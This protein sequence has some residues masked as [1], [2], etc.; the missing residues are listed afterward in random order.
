MEQCDVNKTSVEALED[1]YSTVSWS[2]I[3]IFVPLITAFGLLCNSAFIFVVYRVKAMHTIT[4]VF[5][6]NLAI[7]DFS[8]LTVGLSQYIGSYANSPKYD[9]GFSFYT[10]FGCITPNFLIY[11]C[12][13]ASLWTVTLVSVERY[14]A[15]CHTIWHRHVKSTR[16]AL[17]LV[18]V[19]W[20]IS[21]LFAIPTIP[22]RYIQTICVFSSDIDDEIVELMPQCWHRCKSCIAVLYITDLLQFMI[23]LIV[24]VVLYSLIVRRLT[25]STKLHEVQRHKSQ[26]AAHPRRNTVARMLIVNTI[27]FFVCLTP[28]AIVNV[29]NLRYVFNLSTSDSIIKLPLRWV[30]RVLFLFNSALNPIVYNATNSKYRLAFQEVFLPSRYSRSIHS[31]SSKITQVW[32]D[33]ALS[34]HIV[35]L[36][37]RYDKRRWLQV[38]QKQL[39]FDNTDV[40]HVSRFNK[41]W[42]S[43]TAV[44]YYFNNSNMMGFCQQR[45]DHLHVLRNV[46]I[47]GPFVI[48][49]N[50]S[51]ILRHEINKQPKPVTGQNALVTCVSAFWLLSRF[52]IGHNGYAKNQFTSTSALHR[53]PQNQNITSDPK[54]Q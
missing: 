46:L 12:Y 31:K 30:G 45:V 19:T 16:R 48:P 37:V 49:G 8:L 39:A 44:L 14:L 24:S 38:L 23:A 47:Y 18:V 13:Y 11:L 29:Y 35:S 50:I 3:L 36:L 17:R 7:A 10:V 15:V 28:F 54:R 2:A 27:I 9:L 52:S 34:S 21:V 25:K 6:V 41:W 1:Q 32:T 4:N 5:L 42:S 26:R 43:Y 51:E 22:K 20:I 53:W 33:R 40:F